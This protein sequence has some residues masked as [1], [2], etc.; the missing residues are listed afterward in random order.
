[1]LD[2]NKPIGGL[3]FDDED[4]VVPDGDYRYASSVNTGIGDAKRTGALTNVL[5][6]TKITK[7]TLPYNGGVYPS[8]KNKVIG[9]IEDTQ[10]NSVV[11]FVWNS[12]GKHQILRWFKDKVSVGN[13]YGEVEQIIQYDFGWKRTQ[14]ITGVNIVYGNND[15]NNGDLLYWCDPKPRKI[16]LTKANICNKQKT[17]TLYTGR[18]AVFTLGGTFNFVLQRYDYSFVVQ[19]AIA[20]APTAD[21]ATALEYIANQINLVYGNKITASVC[22][23]GIEITE[24]GT[25]AFWYGTSGF[26]FIIVAE[27]WYGTNLIE[28]YFDRAKYPSL[29]PPIV[30]Y[31]KDATFLP[32]FVKDRLYQF[33]L[34]YQ[35]DDYEKSVLGVIS[36]VPINNLNCNGVSSQNYNYIE[37]DFTANG[38]ISLASMVLLKYVKV[39]ARVGNTGRFREIAMLRPCDF[40]DYVDGDWRA[41]YN[42]YGNEIGAAVGDVE[43]VKLYDNVPLE[44]KDE[45][46]KENRM[47]EYGILEGYN[48]PDCAEA[49]YTIDFTENPQQQGYTI[50]GLV[51]FC[52]FYLDNVGSGGNRNVSPNIAERRAPILFDADADADYPFFGGVM[53]KGGTCDVYQEPATLC[54]QYL[55][56]GGVPVYL[57]GTDFFSISKQKNI[58]AGGIS[59]RSDGSMEAT[60]ISNKDLIKSFYTY[61]AANVGD[62]NYDVFSTFEIRNV[63]NGT[64]VLRLGSHWC[65]FGDKLDKGTMY[66]LSNGRGYQKTSTNVWGFNEYDAN[67]GTYTW[68]PDTE[69]TI[70]VN[71]GDVFIGEV[72]VADLCYYQII[73]ATTSRDVSFQDLRPRTGYLYSSETGVIDLQQ[74]AIGTSVEKAN[75]K[76]AFEATTVYAE[77]FYVQPDITDHNG[78]FYFTQSLEYSGGFGFTITNAFAVQINN[79]SGSSPTIIAQNGVYTTSSGKSALDSLYAETLTFIPLPFSGGSNF[80]SS[81]NLVEAILPVSNVTARQNSVTYIQGKVVDINGQ[82]VSGALVVYEHGKYTY[83]DIDGNYRILAWGDMAD[84]Y[85]FGTPPL[86]QLNRRIVDDL[87]VSSPVCSADYPNGQTIDVDIDPFSGTYSI[88]NPY[89]IADF[90]IDITSS[91][92]QKTHKRGGK[93]VYGLRY[94]D[95]AGRLCSV[96]KAFELYVP[97]I[98][99]DLNLTLPTQYTSGTYKYG[100]PTI[101][102]VLSAGFNPPSFA[103]T[104]Q[105]MRTKDIFYGRYLQ[106][107]ANEV[108]YLSAVASDNVPEVK[109]AFG[110]GDAVAVKI[111]MRGLVFYAQQNPSSRVGY[112]FQQGDRVRLISNADGEYYQGLFEYEVSSYDDNTQE[113]IVNVNVSAPQFTSGMLFEVYNPK[114]NFEDDELVFYEVGEKFNCTAPNTTNN[115]HAT[116]S[117]SFT[118]GDTYWKRRGIIINDTIQSIGGFYPVVVEDASASDFF[119]SNSQDIGRTGII[120]VNFRQTN[121]PSLLRVSDQF[122]PSTLVNGL[123]SF[124]Q[125]NQKE[126]D[127]ADGEAQRLVSIGKQ[128]VAISSNR[129]ISNYIAVVTFQQAANG[130]GVLAVSNQ[131]FGSDYPHAKTLGTDLPASIVLYDGRIFGYHSNR[132]DVWRYQ[133]D[134]EVELNQVKAMTYFNGLKQSGVSD[135]VAVYDRYREMYIL[136]VWRKQPTQIVQLTALGSGTISYTSTDAIALDTEVVV[137]GL[138]ADGRSVVVSG[139]VSGY[140]GTT[141]TVTLDETTRFTNGQNVSVTYSLPETICWFNGSNG[142]TKERWLTFMPFTPECYG[143]IMN[144]VVSFKNGELWLH[145]TNSVRNSFYGVQ[146]NSVI[147]PVFNQNPTAIKA[148]KALW[149]M[150]YQADNQCNW[151]SEN[152]FNNNGQ[153]SRIKSA[154]FVRKEEHW[155]T[156]FKRDITDTTVTN[157]VINGRMMRGT[158]L[159][160][161]LQNDSTS[162]VILYGWMANVMASERTTK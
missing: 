127:R 86:T 89:N 151:S 92:V 126:L 32:N 63:P 81:N 75:V 153:K 111:S 104:F 96:V 150:G 17:W 22:D 55:P 113:I 26:P 140:N 68:K 23:C 148:W 157:P 1:M 15:T 161:E 103:A 67:T 37:V 154:N 98:T 101:N 43:E 53:F 119:I 44:V 108:Q 88:T 120:D 45:C 31:K 152:V 87:I 12:E 73:N 54:K 114:G 10:Y 46:F 25:D 159:N 4:R 135:A 28:Q 69:V 110:N 50:T 14:R 144:D 20:V 128:V 9:S 133:G 77:N 95:V 49:D 18:S 156:E 79:P 2:L 115:Q 145:E 36:K 78:Y 38:L 39:L 59:I 40:L 102:W 121:R 24:K 21:N 41:Y 56:E 106:W 105:W 85:V 97:F 35:Y 147:Q 91:G 60:G 138:T 58:L 71:N 158:T 93:Y 162:E 130:D 117:G 30:S 129:E 84:G 131:Y 142:Y 64:Y 34:E 143:N 94:Y 27:N 160:V 83:T 72:I 146:H 16:N 19:V 33:R 125:A 52:N 65:S 109:T 13:P 149:L 123:S 76:F 29:T 134:G 48:A 137:S 42:F 74:L 62:A 99:E 47:I 136:T 122:I 107:I 100:Q 90:G 57:A 82:A 118:N 61:G 7:Y 51:R 112:Q 116:T 124:Q 5:G 70:T 3:N 8:G 141:V 139:Y 132:A 155:Y 6:N 11:Y 80:S 66:D